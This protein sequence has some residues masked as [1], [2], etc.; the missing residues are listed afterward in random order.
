MDS[1]EP[2]PKSIPQE[3][4]LIDPEVGRLNNLLIYNQPDSETYLAQL[5]DN[6]WFSGSWAHGNGIV[7]KTG[8]LIPAGDG[9]HEPTILRALKQ[10]GLKTEVGEPG[11]KKFIKIGGMVIGSNGISVG[12]FNRNDQRFVTVFKYLHETYTKH[13][14]TNFANWIV[15][16]YSEAGEFK[17]DLRKLEEHHFNLQEVNPEDIIRKHIETPEETRMLD[18]QLNQSIE[19]NAG[20]LCNLG[21]SDKD[22]TFYKYWYRRIYG[23]EYNRDALHSRVDEK[24]SELEELIRVNRKNSKLNQKMS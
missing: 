14:H 16:I 4:I 18:G 23:G 24:L 21:R 3:V 15:T 5:R 8:E 2:V 10:V 9:H 17:Y 12:N 22:I 19:Q 11:G 13:P 7:L 1:H 20:I 6:K